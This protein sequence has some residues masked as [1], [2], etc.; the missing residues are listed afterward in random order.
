MSRLRGDVALR[1]TFA[2]AVAVALAATCLHAVL[3]GDHWYPAVVLVVA[4]VAGLGLAGRRVGLPPL[5]LGPVQVVAVAV[6]C[7]GLYARHQAYA[8]FVPTPAALRALGTLAGDGGQELH[9]VLFPT[10][11]RPDLS[12]LAVAVCGLVALGVDLLAAAARR[13]AFAGLPLVLLVALPAAIRERSVGFL[14]LLAAAIGYLLLLSVDGQERTQRWGRVLP[15]PDAPLP[16]AVAGTAGPALRIGLLSVAAAAVIPFAIPGAASSPFGSGS[17]LGDGSGAGSSA[18]IVDPLVSVSADLKQDSDRTLLTVQTTT[19]SYLRLTALDEFGDGG[20]SLVPISA[21]AAQRVSRGL[22]Q[23]PALALSVPTESISDHVTASHELSEMLLPVPYGPTAVSIHGDWRLSPETATIF[24][25]SSSTRGTTWTAE[26]QVPQPTAAFLAASEPFT[27]PQ[28][29]LPQDVADDTLVPSDLPAIVRQTA[30]SW[31]Q[32]QTTAYGAALA[33]QDH[34]TDGSFVYSTQVSFAPGIQ[35]FEDFLAD[36]TGFCEQYATT[37]AAMLRSLGIPARVA[38]GFVPGTT[39]GNGTYTI[40]GGDA[41]AWPEVWFPGVGWVRF[42]PTP[43]TDHQTTAP[44]YAAGGGATSTAPSPGGAS[45]SPSASATPG[46]TGGGNGSQ[47][48]SGHKRTASASPGSGRGRGSRGSVAALVLVGLLALLVLAALP[49]SL[50]A[51]GRGRRRR[52]HGPGAVEGV[53]QL[54]LDDAA[55]IGAAVPATASPRATGRALLAATTPYGTPAPELR[56]AI[57]RLVAAVERERYAG[58][59]SGRPAGNPAAGTTEESLAD[60]E[61]IVRRALLARLDRGRRLVVVAVPP[62]VR[63]RLRQTWG[64]L[65]PRGLAGLDRFALRRRAA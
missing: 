11:P 38:I 23:D 16:S 22:A 27:P 29:S 51:L 18:T 40:T 36:R 35:G 32:G 34:F 1:Q 33:I 8:G 56:A 5:L 57:G 4:V 49:G 7:V 15:A 39:T 9:D 42:E 52:A 45:P 17:G 43:R 24:S 59:G 64:G 20:F 47:P 50:A 12:L 13:P 31:T 62:S 55:D 26:A 21:S 19:P 6:V 61:R 14:P 48:K 3:L 54:V 30:L 25:S 2:G 60:D 65:L 28:S 63:E 10:T 46:A 58:D 41:H 37:M 53:W 44:V